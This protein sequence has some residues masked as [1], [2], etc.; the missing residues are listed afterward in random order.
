MHV[1]RTVRVDPESVNSAAVDPTPQNKYMRLMVAAFASSNAD[2][3][4]I[5]ARD[6]TIMP[7]IPGLHSILCL[8]FAPLVEM[9]FVVFLNFFQNLISHM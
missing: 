8:L 3:R 4:T 9:R 2:G 1:S 6:T 7:Q 5:M